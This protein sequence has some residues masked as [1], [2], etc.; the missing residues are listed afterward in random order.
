MGGS[1][2]VDTDAIQENMT[3]TATKPMELARSMT[4]TLDKK[5][6][7]LAKT[8]SKKEKIIER[9]TAFIERHVRLLGLEAPS[10]I[11]LPEVLSLARMRAGR[12]KSDGDHQPNREG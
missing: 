3:S 2:W 8:F 10:S 4:N 1:V 6:R 12:G 7:K 9:R 11:C 5:G